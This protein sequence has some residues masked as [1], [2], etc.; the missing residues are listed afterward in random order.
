MGDPPWRIPMWDPPW[1]IPYGRFKISQKAAAPAFGGGWV[2]PVP[3]QARIID[4]I[5]KITMPSE[6]VAM[7]II[8]QSSMLRSFFTLN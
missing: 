4:Q 2:Y 7:T 6:I 8:T 1:G 3:S 5:E